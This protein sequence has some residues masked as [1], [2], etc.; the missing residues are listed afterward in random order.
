MRDLIREHMGAQMQLQTPADGAALICFTSGTSGPPKGVVLSHAA[1]HC[2]VTPP[3][4]DPLSDHPLTW[5][6]IPVMSSARLL[7][8]TGSDSPLIPP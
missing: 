1:L 4:Q 8:L 3:L 5:P 7:T 2:Q 6:D